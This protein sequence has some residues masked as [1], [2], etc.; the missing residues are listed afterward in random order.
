MSH[1]N[2]QGGSILD[3]WALPARASLSEWPWAECRLCLSDILALS[4]QDTF[5]RAKNWVKELQ[6][7]AS[8]NIVIALAGNK[9]DL[10][11]KRAV[12]FQVGAGQDLVGR[13][14]PAPRLAQPRLLR[15]CAEGQVGRPGRFHLLSSR[16]LNVDLKD[17][18]ASPCSLSSA[19]GVCMHTDS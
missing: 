18:S 9:A 2:L 8:P 6:R 3:T 19:G 7:Q 4:P 14:K 1:Q 15:G 13:S 10:A 11:S 16:D 5:A 17:F 12:E